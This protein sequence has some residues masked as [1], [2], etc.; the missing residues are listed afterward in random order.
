MRLVFKTMS[1]GAAHMIVAIAVAY[2]ITGDIMQSL[3]IG[4]LEPLV[5]TGVFALHEVVW[6]GTFKKRFLKLKS[7]INNLF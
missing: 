1:Y 2:C 5:Q 7:Q 3:G 4:I 6:D